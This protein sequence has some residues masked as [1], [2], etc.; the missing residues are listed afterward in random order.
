MLIGL[1]RYLL[2][3]KT[4]QNSLDVSSYNKIILSNPELLTELNKID[5]VKII[6]S[7]QNFN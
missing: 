1:D 4:F 7:K 3:I 6:V 5:Y 2:I